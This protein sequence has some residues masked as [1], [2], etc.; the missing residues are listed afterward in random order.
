[1]G[2]EITEAARREKTLGIGLGQP[3]DLAQPKAQCPPLVIPAKAGIHGAASFRIGSLLHRRWTIRGIRSMEVWIPACAGMTIIGWVKL[4]QRAVP[5]A[6]ID[7]G[8][9]YLDA[10]LSGVADDLGR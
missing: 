5:F 1:M 8:R 9:A 2:V 3:L 4:L 6:E 7:I 10:V